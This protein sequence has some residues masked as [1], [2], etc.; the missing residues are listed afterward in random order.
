[1]T[2]T[3]VVIAIASIAVHFALRE[4]AFERAT[5]RKA[6]VVFPPIYSLRAMFWL[7][8]PAF[9]F[10]AYK[11]CVDVRSSADWAYPFIYIGLAILAFFSD[12]GTITLDDQ[13]I[14]MKKFLGL[15]VKRIGWQD[16]DSAVYSS[17]RKELTVFAKDGRLITHTQF[18]VDPTRFEAELSMRLKTP[19]IHQPS[20][21]R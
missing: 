9:L 20:R 3:P 1:M 7:G 15:R 4:A 11:V 13:G 14:T 18:H 2:P 8:T 21:L 16:T 5:I 19:P 17:A 12:P 10:G 6:K